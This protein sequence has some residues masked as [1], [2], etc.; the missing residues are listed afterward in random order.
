MVSFFE[1]TS[2]RERELFSTFPLT[3]EQEVAFLFWSDINLKL[4]TVRVTDDI[5]VDKT[6]PIRSIFR[7]D[8]T[9]AAARLSK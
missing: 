1:V 3:G 4:R 8:N 6:K 7:V 5:H 9:P 2:D